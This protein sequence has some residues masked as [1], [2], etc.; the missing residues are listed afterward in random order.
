MAYRLMRTE[1]VSDG[2]RRAAR[3][4]IN[5]ALRHLDSSD[6][7]PDDES[8]HEA[9]KSLKKLRAIA[10]LLRRREENTALRDA[11][12]QLSHIRDASAL[13]EA[14]EKLPGSDFSEVKQLMKERHKQIH[15]PAG[16]KAAALSTV[17]ALRNV[18]NRIAEWVPGAKGFETVDSGLKRS[19][20]AGR[21]A[22][23]SAQTQP[24]AGTF[25]ELRKRAKDHWYHVRLLGGAWDAED[26]GREKSL[27]TLQDLLGDQHNFV[28]LGDLLAVE[29]KKSGAKRFE[30]ARAAIDAERSDLEA[31][32]LVLAAEVYTQ[33]PKEH[34]RRIRQAF[35]RWEAEPG[36]RRR[37]PARAK[38]PSAKKT[39]SRRSAA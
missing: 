31:R 12:R 11:G 22:V 28:V 30:A 20:R 35:E 27:K 14:S 25:H 8:I 38:R 5:A 33:K 37:T 36:I 1:V 23:I 29:D 19:Y 21:R 7:V 39:A 18:R 9:R 32:A 34:L 26:R 10:R 3:Q 17:S 4:E 13:L 16:V 6:S 2:L 15:E 24:D